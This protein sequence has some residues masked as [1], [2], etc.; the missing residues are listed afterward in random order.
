MGRTRVNG[1]LLSDM[2]SLSQHSWGLGLASL[3][4]YALMVLL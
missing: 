1:Q 3:Y 4:K 2:Q